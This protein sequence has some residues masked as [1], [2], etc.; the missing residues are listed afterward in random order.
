MIV[1][2]D[3]MLCISSFLL[4][5]SVP[6]VYNVDRWLSIKNDLKEEVRL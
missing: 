6:I 5:F 4:Y 2:K 1:K 3:E